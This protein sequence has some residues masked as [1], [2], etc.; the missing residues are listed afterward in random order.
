MALHAGGQRPRNPTIRT[1]LLRSTSSARRKKQV[2]D[3]IARNS[4]KMKKPLFAPRREKCLFPLPP[5]H[6]TAQRQRRAAAS[7]SPGPDAPGE[8]FRGRQGRVSPPDAPMLATQ[9]SRG[10]AI[11]AAATGTLC[12]HHR[13]SAR[14]RQEAVPA[15][16]RPGAE[17]RF[18]R[19]GGD[20]N[21]RVFRV[22]PLDR[23]PFCGDAFSRGVVTFSPTPAMATQAAPYHPSR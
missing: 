12:P 4:D 7:L 18:R 19:P 9:G 14:C 20:E 6:R 3:S 21:S 17:R 10:P 16:K 8:R 5:C 23:L 15:A 2:N 13:R 1:R 22:E 11:P